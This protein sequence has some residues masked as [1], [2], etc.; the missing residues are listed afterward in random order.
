MAE[1]VSHSF[2]LALTLALTL[3]YI[4]ITAGHMALFG[5]SP[6]SL[7]DPEFCCCRL[8]QSMM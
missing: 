4:H 7:N 6:T 8:P 3:S 2:S 1:N 5:G